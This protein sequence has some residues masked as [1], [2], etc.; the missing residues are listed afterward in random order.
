ML[1]Y[2]HPAV[3]SILLYN[4][5][6]RTVTTNTNL[7][8]L[9]VK[10]YQKSTTALLPGSERVAY[11]GASGLRLQEAGSINRSLAAL[12]N[13]IKVRPSSCKPVCVRTWS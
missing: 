3:S 5:L 10:A 8:V 6:C 13:V 7:Y 12:S 9:C 2:A 1:H 11:T 4:T